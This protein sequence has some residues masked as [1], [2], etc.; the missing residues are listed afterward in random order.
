MVNVAVVKMGVSSKG[1]A[2]FKHGRAALLALAQQGDAGAHTEIQRRIAGGSELYSDYVPPGPTQ[3]QPT[4][5]DPPPPTPTVPQPPTGGPTPSNVSCRRCL[6]SHAT[7]D[8]P[9]GS[10]T[11]TVTS[12]PPPPSAGV[13]VVPAKKVPNPRSSAQRPF[14]KYTKK[15]L[16][17]AVAA[18]LP[19]ALEEQQNRGIWREEKEQK[20][21]APAS[22]GG[23]SLKQLSGKELRD[24]AARG[25]EPARSEIARRAANRAA[26]G[27]KPVGVR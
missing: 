7:E 2:Y 19:G 12:P 16:E 3:P 8:C 26:K 27:Q 14:F 24:L 1:N 5:L 23:G 13:A 6:G 20:K 18:G 15:Q 22:M 11:P 10:V 4:T 21:R 25:F 9:G 17:A